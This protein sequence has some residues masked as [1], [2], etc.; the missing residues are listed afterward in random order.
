M[1]Y[2]LIVLE[3]LLYLTNPERALRIGGSDSDK[4]INIVTVVE[5]GLYRNI[6][7]LIR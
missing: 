6:F 7:F 5:Q 4:I 1:H 2:P 3:E